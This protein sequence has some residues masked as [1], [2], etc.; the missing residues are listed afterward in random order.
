MNTWTTVFGFHKI[1]DL[2]KKEMKSMNMLVFPGTDMLHKE[3]VKQE[4]SDGV[5]VSESTNNQPQLPGLVNNSDIEPSLEQKQNSDEDDVLDSGPSNAICE[6]D[7][8]TAAANSAEVENEQK[9]E[10]YANLNSSPSPDECNNRQ[11]GNEE[12]EF[13][14][15]GEK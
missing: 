6:S 10:S 9:E 12:F 3:L 7:N 4:N 8:N 13:T 15:W 11:I 2:H 14:G 5:K 1:E